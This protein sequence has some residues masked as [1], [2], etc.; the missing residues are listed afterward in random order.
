[1]PSVARGSGL[2]ALSLKQIRA[3]RA[4]AQASHPCMW[5]RDEA[6][7]DFDRHTA[8]AL[9]LVAGDIAPVIDITSRR[10]R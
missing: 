9:A 5:R 4:A 2:K 7:A 1:M 8:T 10:P 6:A 3:R